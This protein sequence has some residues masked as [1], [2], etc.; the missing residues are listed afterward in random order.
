MGQWGTGSQGGKS[1]NRGKEKLNRQLTLLPVSV[2]AAF[3]D[4]KRLNA[5]IPQMESPLAG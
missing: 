1:T 3:C 2:I 5:A 4:I